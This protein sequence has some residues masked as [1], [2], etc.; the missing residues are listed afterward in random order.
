MQNAYT[1]HKMCEAVPVQAVHKYRKCGGMAP[2]ILNLSRP[3]RW[4]VIFTYQIF[5]HRGKNPWYP[6]NKRSLD[7]VCSQYFHFR[8][9]QVTTEVH[10]AAYTAIT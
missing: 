3:Q 8:K 4:A 9:Y 7:K 2:L 5:C 10:V 6:V 1:E